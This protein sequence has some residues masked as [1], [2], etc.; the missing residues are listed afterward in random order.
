MRI[1]RRH[2]FE[3]V[4]TCVCM[5]AHEKKETKKHR[6]RNVKVGVDWV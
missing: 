1:R 2:A 4:N 6:G 5:Q 3:C